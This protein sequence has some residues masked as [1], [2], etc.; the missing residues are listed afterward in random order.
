MHCWK[1]I[2]IKHEYGTTRL[3]L[4]SAITFL[5]VFSFSFIFSPVHPSLYK[6]DYFILFFITILF[7][8]PIHKYTHYVS[9]FKNRR[10]VKLKWKVEYFIVPIFH[11]RI[12]KLINKNRY[13]FTLLAPFLFLNIM[14]ILFA[15]F[16]PHYAHYFCLLL[17]FHTS[18]CIPDLL[19]V[20]HLIKAP[21]DA[22]IE[23]TPKGYEIL[24]PLNR[25]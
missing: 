6:D 4:Y 17:G 22:M 21:K 23:E 25:N 1:V 16:F 12:K 7:M 5:F 18:I 11:I 13:I 24:V 19:Y 2:N 15:I 9:L 14:I 20:K 3:F 8:Y 10:N